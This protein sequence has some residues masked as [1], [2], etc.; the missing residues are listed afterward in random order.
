M[1]SSSCVFEFGVP[2]PLASAHVGSCI[3]LCRAFCSIYSKMFYFDAWPRPLCVESLWVCCSILDLDKL[4]RVPIAGPSG[5]IV[6]IPV[7]CD[8]S[9]LLWEDVKSKWVEGPE[10]SGAWP[11]LALLGILPIVWDCK[12]AVELGSKDPRWVKDVVAPS[13]VPSSPASVVLTAPLEPAL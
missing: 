6:E 13:L 11:P 1:C 5:A 3:C 7:I 12:S 9:G 8:I 10:D 4:L 2:A